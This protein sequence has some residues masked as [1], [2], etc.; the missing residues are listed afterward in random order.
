LRH[1]A[2][3]PPAA[4][5]D[6]VGPPTLAGLWGART[7]SSLQIQRIERSGLSFRTPQAA[8]VRKGV[9][10]NWVM[11]I[12]KPSRTYTVEPLEDPVPRE[13]PEESPEREEPAEPQ[14][15]PEKVPA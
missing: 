15:E 1:S 2:P 3:E 5:V 6:R 13:L 14:R 7:R 9:H 8:V 4:E 11:D 10:S 12:G